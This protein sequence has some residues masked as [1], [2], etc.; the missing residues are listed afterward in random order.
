M[1]D[2]RIRV[3]HRLATPI[4]NEQKVLDDMM[5][6]C[7]DFQYSFEAVPMLDA[8]GECPLEDA[9][10]AYVSAIRQ[11]RLEDLFTLRERL[12]RRNS[13]SFSRRFFAPI[14]NDEIAARRTL[15]QRTLAKGGR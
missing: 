6:P 7:R 15:S 1:R 8:A 3:T 10:V 2:K 13:S 9:L 5:V 4:R 11:L 14:V 12:A